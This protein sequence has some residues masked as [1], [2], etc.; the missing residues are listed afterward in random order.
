MNG[1]VGEF[2]ILVGMFPAR[3]DANARGAEWHLLAVA[4]LAVSAWCWG[5]VHVVA[6]AADSFGP[7]R[8]PAHTESAHG[9]AHAA[10]MLRSAI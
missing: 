1:F 6:G 5:V 4:V 9:A 7:L 2:S 8:E 10:P 3:L